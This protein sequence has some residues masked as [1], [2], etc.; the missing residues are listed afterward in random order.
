MDD[1]GKFTPQYHK[2]DGISDK[3]RLPRIDKIRLGIKEISV[4]SGKEFPKEVDY[5]VCPQDVKARFGEEPKELEIMFPLDNPAEIFPQSLTYYGSSKGVKCKGNRKTA[6][7]KAEDCEGDCH[8]HSTNEKWHTR[9][10]PCEKYGKGCTLRGHLMFMIPSVNIGGVYQLDTTSLNST[11]DINS[12]IDYIFALC[13][14][15]SM[16]PIILKRLPKET[17]HEEKKQTHYTM[18][19]ELRANIDE[20]ADI[21][22]SPDMIFMRKPDGTLRAVQGILNKQQYALPKPVEENPELDTG[23]VRIAILEPEIEKSE[24]KKTPPED[25]PPEKKVHI[26]TRSQFYKLPKSERLKT[27]KEVM[28]LLGVNEKDLDT[29]VPLDEHSMAELE[30]SYDFVLQSKGM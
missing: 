20:L 8:D 7:R 29:P 27:V 1:Q 21:K 30:A 19:L 13:G 9:D 18:H 16:I 25:I 26:K 3:R 12:G 11:I 5:F 23:G 4:K 22:A 17:H 2:V 28:K 6:S 24:L 10:C 14:R 15:I